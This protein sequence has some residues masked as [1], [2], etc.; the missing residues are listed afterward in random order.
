MLF[1]WA[2]WDLRRKALRDVRLRVRTNSGVEVPIGQEHWPARS[3]RQLR[4]WCKLAVGRLGNAC[5]SWLEPEEPTHAS[6]NL[7]WSS[8]PTGEPD[9]G[10]PPV[11]FGGRGKAIFPYPYFSLVTVTQNQQEL[12]RSMP[13]RTLQPPIS[14]HGVSPRF[15]AS[16]PSNRRAASKATSK[17]APA[18]PFFIVTS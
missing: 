17:A 2:C 8:P 6:T 13:A 12:H 9:A 14:S 3:G 1:T 5:Q 15:S 16:L 4:R 11:R 18:E 10:N 7:L